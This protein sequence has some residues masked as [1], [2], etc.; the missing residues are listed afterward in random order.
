[1][2]E[3]EHAASA[4]LASARLQA[5]AL[6]A[7]AHAETTTLAAEVRGASLYLFAQ[8]CC[9]LINLCIGF[10]H[11]SLFWRTPT[12]SFRRTVRFCEVLPSVIILCCTPYIARAEKQL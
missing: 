12:W 11:K 7:R 5:N 6:Q 9:Y 4:Q 10:C 3:R 2:L 1:M 8:T